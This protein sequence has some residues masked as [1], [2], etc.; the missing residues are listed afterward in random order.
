[1]SEF[2]ARLLD[3]VTDPVA[4]Q[5]LR[6]PIRLASGE[7][8]RDFIDAKVAVDDPDDLDFVG[9]AMVAAARHANVE[10]DAVGGVVLGAVP[11]TFAVAGVARC[12]WFL[13]RKE[14]KGRGT[15][16]WI[17]GARIIAGMRVLLVEDVVTTGG[18]IRDAYERVGLEGGNVVF[19]TTLVDRG[20]EAAGFFAG[21]GVPY[22]PMLTYDDLGIEPVGRPG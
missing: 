5:H 13:I 12:K 9:R 6:E 19:A 16:R 15:N 8:S 17:E 7:M 1:M 22:I 18:S 3:I 4:L 21:V 11:F 14:P 10:F 20:D 2:A